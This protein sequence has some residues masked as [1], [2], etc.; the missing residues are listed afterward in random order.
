MILGA[1]I[2]AGFCSGKEVVSYFAIYGYYSIPICL[3]CGVL[4]FFVMRIF[5]LAGKY[6]ND[7][8]FGKLNFINIMATMIIISSM[9]AGSISV[10]NSSNM[11]VTFGVYMLTIAATIVVCSGGV[12]SVDKINK[13]L[14][15]VIIVILLFTCILSWSIPSNFNMP[16]TV[17]A[18]VYICGGVG[19][20]I[21][22]I[23][24]N[25]LLM[26]MFLFSVG[27]KYTSR[28][29]TKA[30]AISSAVITVMLIVLSVTLIN[31]NYT[32]F[33]SDM[34]VLAIAQSISPIL[35]YLVRCVVWF[36]LVT[37]L[38]ASTH[39]VCEYLPK[40]RDNRLICIAG[41][42]GVCSVVSIVGFSAIVTYL[43]FIVGI[44]GVVYTVNIISFYLKHKK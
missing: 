23:C 29:V 11:L 12:K 16:N 4:L 2:G 10:A 5:L 27:R 35:Y 28:Q 41:I 31:T 36:G 19:S 39:T 24:F 20:G 25:L 26:G 7:S 13:Y 32:I 22:Y 44:M 17:S 6:F 14:V 15:P 40:F 1:F 43:Y 37:T 18:I 38:I 8:Q 21:N 3:M 34:P 33:T 9:I 30:C 42:L